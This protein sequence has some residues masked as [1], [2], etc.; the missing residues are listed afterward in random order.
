MT[1]SQNKHGKNKNELA[2]R[3]L[4]WVLIALM[5]L[6]MIIPSLTWIFTLNVS[7]AYDTNTD[8]TI[9]RI[10]LLYGTSVVP[11]FQTRSPYGFTVC[12][13]DKESDEVTEIYPLS[14]TKV[15]ESTVD[16]NLKIEGGDYLPT[17]SDSC[18]IGAYHAMLETPLSLGEVYMAM[19]AAIDNGSNVPMLVYYTNGAY[20]LLVG[21]FKSASAAQAY[22]DASGNIFEGFT[23]VSGDPVGSMVVREPSPSAVRLIDFETNMTVFLYDGL[24]TEELGVMARDAEDGTTAYLQTPANKLY[25]GVFIF[26]RH[27][28]GIELVNLIGL[29][30]YILGVL[31]YE[32][33]NSWPLET[34]KAFAVAVRSYTVNTSGKHT[35]TYGF[36]MCNTV[37]CQA[38]HGVRNVNDTVREAVSATRDLVLVSNEGDIITTYYSAVAGGTTVSAKQ[39]WGGSG[40]PYLLAQQTPWEDYSSHT[41]GTWKWSVSPHDLANVLVS[42]GYTDIKGAIADIQVEYADNS[43]YV[44]SIT[45]TDVSGNKV[46]IKNTDTVRS[47][48]SSYLKSANFVVGRSS[49]IVN[50]P[51]FG[52]ESAKRLFS[53]LG[54]DNMITYVNWTDP[55]TV[56][57]SR[58]YEY[59]WAGV[60]T[61]V[62]TSSGEVSTVD[63]TVEIKAD[64]SDHFLFVGRGWGH[65]VGLSQVGAYCLGLQGF[66][67]DFILQA[68]FANTHLEY[69]SDRTE[70][71]VA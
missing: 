34:Q 70:E 61:P 64:N 10:G 49:V 38:Y 26:S 13:V 41:N 65:G 37:C 36:D 21:S 59:T 45:F 39:A 25:D 46:T 15:L 54:S 28:Q 18:D 29:E 16:K 67:S 57:T 47:R 69:Y 2:K 11:A 43:A 4:V 14:G 50:D 55:M 17:D 3:V 56:A 23:T 58:G 20:F 24:D 68:Y 52:S 51:A 1:L 44:Y 31:P 60:D 22:I 32:I 7:A 35:K 30:D 8:D 6:G 71:T 33:S 62:L 66:D 63:R 48:L 12:T 42:K 5:V 9:V 40:A 53:R 27:E 19:Y